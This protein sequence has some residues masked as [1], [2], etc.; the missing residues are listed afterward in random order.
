MEIYVEKIIIFNILIHL[1]LVF[2]TRYLTNDKVRKVGLISSVLLGVINMY[3]FFFT[4]SF[5]NY[6]LIIIIALICFKSIKSTLLYIMFNLIL[7]GIT[8]VINLSIQYYYETILLCSISIIIFIY[9][10]RKEKNEY[11]IS[12]NNKIYNCFYDTGCIISLGLTPVIVV[13]ANLNI[14]LVYFSDI[15]INTIEG[16]NIHKVYKA[17]DVY[18]IK[19]KVKIYKNC[20]IIKS[21]IDYDVIIGKN[22]IGG[23]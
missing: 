2:A 12:I 6:I 11:K 15:E 23:I 20:L 9:F 3:I 7:G 19:N 21:N 1:T 4:P 18:L 10:L 13:N 16:I 8:G 5:I 14:E 22:F 17:K